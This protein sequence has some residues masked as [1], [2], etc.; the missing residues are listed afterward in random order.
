MCLAPTLSEA[1]CVRHHGR[2]D[3]CDPLLTALVQKPPVCQQGHAPSSVSKG[4]RLPPPPDPPGL[5]AAPLQPL[6]R[7]PVAYSL[8]PFPSH[9][10]TGHWVTPPPSLSLHLNHLPLQDPV[11]KSGHLLGF[12]AGPNSGDI[13]RNFNIVL[14]E[15]LVRFWLN[16]QKRKNPIMRVWDMGQGH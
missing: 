11:S 16:P 1:G 3:Q 13:T 15:E 12:R 10:D 2:V 6:P 8:F 9:R 14:P 7:L 4:G 5:L